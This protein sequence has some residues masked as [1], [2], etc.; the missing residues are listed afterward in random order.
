MATRNTVYADAVQFP[1]D[2][3]SLNVNCACSKG[4]RTTRRSRGICSPQFQ[5]WPHE[6]FRRDAHTIHTVQESRRVHRNLRYV[7]TQGNVHMHIAQYCD[8]VRK[9]LLVR[10]FGTQSAAE[11]CPEISCT[12]DF[13]PS[14]SIGK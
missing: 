7:W 13:N 12:L 2:T 9:Q 3:I 14:K 10:N 5:T 8:F 4:Q 11:V 6:L 1:C